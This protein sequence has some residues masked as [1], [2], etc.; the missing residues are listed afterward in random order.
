MNEQRLTR[1]RLESVR[2]IKRRIAQDSKTLD[3]LLSEL[4]EDIKAL[5]YSPIP[6]SKT[7]ATRDLSDGLSEYV[8]KVKRY[9]QKVLDRK[10]YLVGLLSEID[11]FLDSLEREEEQEIITLHCIEGKSFREIGDMMNTSKSSVQRLYFKT[12]SREGVV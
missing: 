12:L 9:Q 2:S 11:A 1:K 6:K 8:D 7:N 3:E 4:P 10:R 5:S